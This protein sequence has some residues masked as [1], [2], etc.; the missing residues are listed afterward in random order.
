MLRIALLAMLCWAVGARLPA[1]DSKRDKA[2]ASFQ[3]KV[4]LVLVPVVVRNS[5][6]DP[7]GSLTRDNF[8]LF[9][10]GKLQTITSFSRMSHRL[11]GNS[12][13]AGRPSNTSSAG[14]AT[15]AE[16]ETPADGAA[17]RYLIYLFDDINTRFADMAHLRAAAARHFQKP[18]N[19]NDRIAIYSLSGRL[20]SE[21]THDPQQLQKEVEQLRWRPE[22]GH[23][24]TQCPDV[25][26]YVAD[27]IVNR[28]D[29]QALAAL[30]RHTEDC[31]H[32]PQW[33][34][35]PIAKASAL[36][37]LNIGAQDNA[38][39][40]ATLRRAIKRLSRMEGQRI[41]ILS[42]AGFVIR[43]PEVSRS[44]ERV[45][46]MAARDGVVINGLSPRGTIMAEE[47]ENVAEEKGA[48]LRPPSQDSPAEKWKMY[49]EQSADAN[50]DLVKYLV[51]ST[52]GVFFH[53]NGNL[54]LGFARTANAPEYSYLLGFSPD[55]SKMDGSLHRLKVRLQNVKGDR[56]E[57][58][59]GYYATPEARSSNDL[60]ADEIEDAVFARN[61]RHD[62]PVVL[63][64]G[65][66]KQNGSNSAT[67]NIVAKV[68]ISGLHLQKQGDQS[69]DTFRAVAALFDA[70]GAYVA[71]SAHTVT[72]KLS[73]QNLA[74]LSAQPDPGITLRWAFPVQTGSYLM[75]LVIR[76]T[77][78][79]AFT[80]INHP[81]VV[82]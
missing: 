21:F 56:V 64:D 77:S 32:V 45:L 3:T 37:E 82:Q 5:K 31:A 2:Q 78:G 72:L 24:G 35:E 29:A 52:G 39:V 40:L 70:S 41:I 18:L 80:A 11:I 63:Q 1:Q 69:D 67:V 71:G 51:E 13:I 7:V 73:K 68:G 49:R 55:A 23:G 79:G 9:D 26:Y 36:R 61:L 10:S 76:E 12:G 33:S 17:P 65:Y 74:E 46:E 43:T 48:V 47:T 59:N 42:S 44:L 30:T 14:A 15:L 28:N 62:I 66:S 50:A 60:A 6:G 22:V 20:S 54:D 19:T 53:N 38:V 16:K 27:L 81:L 34:A 4:N 57:A 8:R 75:R 58:R 25:S